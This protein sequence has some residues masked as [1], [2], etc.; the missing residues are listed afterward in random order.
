MC[1]SVLHGEATEFFQSY[2]VLQLYLLIPSQY[3]C[4]YFAKSDS[5]YWSE[6]FVATC[7][8]ASRAVSL[9]SRAAAPL[10]FRL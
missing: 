10:R 8:A 2:F 6:C 7:F 1:I 4:Q 9:L 5:G 3:L